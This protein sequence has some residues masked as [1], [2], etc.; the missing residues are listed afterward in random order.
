[1]S[2]A[3]PIAAPSRTFSINRSHFPRRHLSRRRGHLRQDPR[4]LQGNRRCL[5]LWPLRRH[6]RISRRRAH[7]QPAR[8]PHLGIDESGARAHA[9]PGE[10]TGRPRTRPAASVEFHAL[11]VPAPCRGQRRDGALRARLLSAHRLALCARQTHPR[12]P[13][14]LCAPAGRPH[15]RNRHQL[16]R[17]SQ[18]A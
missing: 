16:H 15:H 6:G 7:P 8:Q 1:M 18:Y 5:S 13:P 9:G 12:H 3:S 11:D 14:L 17:R 2:I 10:G 4:H